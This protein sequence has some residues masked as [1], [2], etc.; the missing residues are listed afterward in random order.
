MLKTRNP[1]FDMVSSAISHKFSNKMQR[2]GI[3]PLFVTLF[4]SDVSSSCISEFL[5]T[6]LRCISKFK[7][8][9]SCGS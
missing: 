9:I 5:S 7:V 4:S 2:R 1:E 8:D 6:W 3:T